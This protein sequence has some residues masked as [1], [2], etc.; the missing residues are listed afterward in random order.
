MKKNVILL[1]A[2]SM[3][4]LLLTGC[5]TGQATAPPKY[6]SAPSGGGCGVAAPADSS[7]TGELA[8]SIANTGGL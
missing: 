1:I 8:E 2:L 3:A 5:I 4:L 7:N 6:P